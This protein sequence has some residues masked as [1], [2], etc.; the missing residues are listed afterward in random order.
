MLLEVGDWL[1]KQTVPSH[2]TNFNQEIDLK[3]YNKA[4]ELACVIGEFVRG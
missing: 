1:L 2:H 3:R 4:R